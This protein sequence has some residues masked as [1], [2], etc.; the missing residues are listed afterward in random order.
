MNTKTNALL[1]ATLLLAGCMGDG[2]GGIAPAQPAATTVK[3]DFLHKP[4]PEIPLPNDIA[5]RYDPT[6]ATG[7]RVNASMLAPT[8]F[9]SRIRELIDGL[10]G[11]GVFEQITIPFTGPLDV[12]SILAGHRDID[13][14]LSNDVLYLINIDRSSPEFGRVH[15]VD[16]GEGN[17]P[18]VLE[19]I[20]KYWKNDPRGWTESLAFEEEDEDLN[21]N[22]VLD[23]G[24]DTDGDGIL[25][26][27]NYLPGKKPDRDDL[28][29]RADA[30]MGFYEAQTHTLLTRPLIPLRER[31]TY[32]VVV[33]RRLK[34]AQ[35]RPV[36]SPY[37]YV[38]HASQ[39]AA[40]SILPEVLPQGLEIDDVAFAFSFT[41]QSIQSHIQAVRDGLYGHGVQ[42]HLGQNFPAEVAGL[43]K[44]KDPEHFKQMKN[45]YVMYAEQFAGMYD[46]ILSEVDGK[47]PASTGYKALVD[48]QSYVDFHAIGSFKSPQL[49]MR[50]DDAGNFLGLN[51][52]SWPPDLDR[53]VAPTRDETVYFWLIVPRKEVS[54]RGQGKP[55]PVI[56][57]G[58]GYTSSRFEAVAFGGFLARQGFAVLAIDC[59]SHGLSINAAEEAM[60]KGYADSFGLL[61][62]VEAALKNR[63]LDMNHDGQRDS[64]GDYWTAYMFHTR[65][66]VR[67]SALDY[68]QLI[69]VFSA[70]DGKNKWS[71]D[72]NG[73]GVANDIAGDFDG[74]GVVDVGGTADYHMTGGSLGGIMSLM[75][76]GIEPK[77]TSIMP[78]AGAAGLGE[79][80]VRSRQGGVPEPVWLRLMGPLYVGTPDEENGT[81]KLETIIPDLNDRKELHIGDATGVSAGDTV[82]VEN[83]VNQKRGCGYVDPEGRFR[84][85]V[86]S[87]LGDETRLLFYRGEVITGE[88]CELKQGIVP[89]LTFDTLQQNVF[90]QGKTVDSGTKLHALAEGL[91]LRR[92]HPKLRRFSSLTQLVL[93]PG[94]P[95][96]YARHY[97]LEPLVYA[98]GE[99]TGTHTLMVPTVGDMNVPVSTGVTAARA[100][101][102]LDFLRPDPRYG[103]SANQVLID[104]Y[105]LEATDRTKRF[106]DSSGNGVMKD[107]DDFSGGKD[108]FGSEVPRLS[109]P[110]RVGVGRVDRL[111]GASAMLLPISSATGTHGFDRPGEMADDARKQCEKD[112]PDKTGENP[113]GCKTREYFDIGHFMF[114]LMGDYARSGGKKL[115]IR[116]CYSRDDCPDM[117]KP[118]DARDV[119]TLP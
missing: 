87:D 60:V 102:L 97:Q 61:P 103:K 49:F 88:D 100:A 4:L 24:E 91:G 43:E 68:M 78:I 37:P 116:S 36:G 8:G 23:P 53:V 33:T 86:E 82:V 29:A 92:A 66:Q 95:V 85:A 113:C 73:D 16:L 90:F 54:P 1:A 96:S 58:H 93:D 3:M 48:A 99:Q 42:A 56:I 12:S 31:T 98:T 69:R 81:T 45:P 74:D 5:T 62:M 34:D 114:N 7:R 65:D 59:P 18:I 27:P 104:E 84:V 106:T 25:D 6:S 55:A 44:L 105:V 94:D 21:D 19:E 119:D 117:A 77:L 39:T 89:Y 20:D 13:Y 15:H 14:D 110:L 11:W 76:G 67:Q 57:L 72:V 118:P 70:F 111:G 71:I 101:G 2:A 30:L 51:D 107:V 35:G 28:G 38:N 9:E 112:C 50:N 22:G 80:A 115:E 41:T 75:V 47:D 109:P 26:K 10:D 40:L 83:M 79:V 52:Q 64:G 63:A 32:A 46:L 17:Y 108:R